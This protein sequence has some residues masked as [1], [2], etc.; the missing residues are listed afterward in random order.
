MAFLEA[1]RPFLMKL[2]HKETSNRLV[3]ILWLSFR[4]FSIGTTDPLNAAIS[5]LA[6]EAVHEV[7]QLPVHELE[8]RD[9]QQAIANLLQH[10]REI[11]REAIH[12]SGSDLANQADTILTQARSMKCFRLNQDIQSIASKAKRDISLLKIDHTYPEAAQF[13]F[14]GCFHLLFRKESF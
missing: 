6:N 1:H 10:F 11:T 5:K 7:E 12:R 13:I 3:H 4:S 9:V 14:A 8:K 2:L